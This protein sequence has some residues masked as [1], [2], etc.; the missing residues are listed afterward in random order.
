MHL[1]IVIAVIAFIIDVLL[2][3][4]S[5]FIVILTICSCILLHWCCILGELRLMLAY[6]FVDFTSARLKIWIDDLEL[7]DQVSHIDATLLS[8]SILLD[9]KE[10]KG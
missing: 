2:A 5:P 4:S 9:S 1:Y 7:D 3:I 6:L 8:C 10:S